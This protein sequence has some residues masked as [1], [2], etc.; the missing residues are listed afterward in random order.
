MA[1]VTAKLSAKV[2]EK[3]VT[4]V[5]KQQQNVKMPGSESPFQQ[6]LSSLGNGQGFA[7]N[8]GIG[9]QQI[10]IPTSE[11]NAISARGIAIDESNLMYGL[12]QPNGIEKV[13]NLLSDVNNGQMQMENL[14]NQILYSGK[15]FSNQELLAIQAHVFHFA[16]ITE[17]VVKAADQGVSSIKSVLNT[18]V[19]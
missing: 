4:E 5:A 12:D 2:I 15:K 10:G 11:T 7:A 8:V 9:N 3:T 17:L 1:G 6:M 18:N 19:Q 14:V 16:Q 13:I